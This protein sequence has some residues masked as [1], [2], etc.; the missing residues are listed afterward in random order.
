MLASASSSSLSLAPLDISS[1]L[2]A[3]LELPGSNRLLHRRHGIFFLIIHGTTYSS[4]FLNVL[5][6]I[7]C[8]HRIFVVVGTYQP[9]STMYND[10]IGYPNEPSKSQGPERSKM[11]MGVCHWEPYHRQVHIQEVAKFDLEAAR[12]MLACVA[13]SSCCRATKLMRRS[14]GSERESC[15]LA[16]VRRGQI[17]GRRRH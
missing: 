4:P 1:G 5:A 2:L 15:E 10:P 17:L 3:G 7:W 9:T 14:G 13:G 8:L 6:Q 11:L 16:G 12:A